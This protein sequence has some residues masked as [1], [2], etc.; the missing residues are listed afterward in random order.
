MSDVES[1]GDTLGTKINT[2][3][4]GHEIQIIADNATDAVKELKILVKELKEDE[5]RS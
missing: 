2:V 1:T 3:I 5:Q 4:W